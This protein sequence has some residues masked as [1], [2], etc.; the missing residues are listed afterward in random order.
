[1]ATNAYGFTYPIEDAANDVPVD[2][3]AAAD[4]IGP[5]SNM[6]F[7][8]AAARDALLTA[9]VEGMRCWL[10][11]INQWSYYDGLVWRPES[12]FAMAAGTVTVVVTAAATGTATVTFPSGRFTVAPIINITLTDP[13]TGSQKLVPRVT[14]PTSGGFTATVFTGDAST[15]TATVVLHWTA[16]QMLSATAAG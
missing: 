10:Q 6:R 7:A 12:A 13:A 9:P 1:V 5:Y 16:V 11:D 15:T 3:K 2:I 4:S 14:S 8:N